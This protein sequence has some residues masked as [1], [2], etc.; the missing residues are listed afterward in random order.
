MIEE[1]EIPWSQEAEKAILGQILDDNVH[2]LAASE[3]VKDE[4]FLL[5][6]HRRI[7]NRISVMMKAGERVDLVTLGAALSASKEIQEVG[8]WGYLADL[9]TGLLK[10]KN[11]DPYIDL[12]LQKAQ[13]RRLL[14]F[15]DAI[16]QQCLDNTDPLLILP[17]AEKELY[18]VASAAEKEI[19]NAERSEQVFESL[20]RQREGKETKFLPSGID[21]IDK[22]Y[23]GYAVGELTVI[24]GRPKQGKS[25]AVMQA[26]AHN[27]TQG[28]PVDLFTMEMRDDAVRMRLWAILASVPFHK[29]R[30]P[31]RMNEMELTYV[32]SAMKD[33]ARWP[34]YIC[35]KKLTADEV[36]TKAK[37]GKLRRG[38]KVVAVDYLQKLRFIGKMDQ[39][40]AAIS[41]ASMKMADLANSTGMAVLLLSSLTEAK[42][43]H[44]N[45]PPTLQDLRG[46]GDIQYDCHSAYLIHREVNR[47]TEKLETRGQ[48]ILAAARSDAGGALDVKYDE[49]YLTFY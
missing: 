16:Q 24:A 31:E 17:W 2:W 29:I 36:V 38:T 6:S 42:G 7:W 18:E 48:F 19:S 45:D 46:S 34:L 23:G 43:R 3:R 13:L 26:I 9:T 40:Y 10:T 33:V 1:Q 21:V 35:D 47:D 4:V 5:D 11:L 49:N 22:V 12:L 37:I 41:D 20:M 30:H 44:R 32:K 28:Y 39:R 14:R 15:G 25:S 8:G 27:C